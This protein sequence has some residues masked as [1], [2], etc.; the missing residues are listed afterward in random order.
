MKTNGE[1][2]TLL[3][4][5]LDSV[6]YSQIIETLTSG[7]IYKKPW[8]IIPDNIANRIPEPYLSIIN[9]CFRGKSHINP[10]E[11]FGEQLTKSLKEEQILVKD[12]E[13]LW[14]LGKKCIIPF[15]GIY[16]LTDLW[17]PGQKVQSNQ[18]WIGDDSVYLARLLPVMMGK[19]VLDLCTGSG[20]QSLI[21]GSRGANVSAVDINERAIKV[22]KINTKLND[23]EDSIKVFHGDLYES[24]PNEKY[25]FIVS[26]PPFM[27][28]AKSYNDVFLCADGGDDGTEILKK[29]LKDL[30]KY[31]VED[32]SAILIA[33][34]FGDD[35]EPKI[36]KYL[37]VLSEENSWTTQ[38][39]IIGKSTAKDEIKRLGK[40]F[41]ELYKNMISTLDD[42]NID[43]TNYYS[44]VISI[45]NNGKDGRTNIIPCHI[46]WADKL[47]ELRRR[48]NN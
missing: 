39:I 46:S 16:I 5:L 38:L 30:N 37:K 4:D 8:T 10:E 15:Q 31:L 43:Y 3:S 25:D 13:G 11:V 19:K 36:V 20:I 24:L 47:K 23:L 21:M 26:N 1:G 41:P 28:M 40:Q 33:G 17:K 2:F 7:E 34:G 32:G 14:N 42:S 9:I 48:E 45:M 29:I 18:V 6:S 27:P 44:F 35:K 22:A 12:D